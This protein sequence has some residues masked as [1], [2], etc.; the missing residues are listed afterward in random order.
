MKSWLVGCAVLSNSVLGLGQGE[1]VVESSSKEEVASPHAGHQVR[2]HRDHRGPAGHDHEQLPGRRAE[3]L[4]G[5]VPLRREVLP[6][7]RH[8]HA[9][10]HHPGYPPL[11]QA[12]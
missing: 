10:R 3:R 7:H 8:V 12:S 2:Q 6:K 9:A 4:E 1:Q 5:E 11:T